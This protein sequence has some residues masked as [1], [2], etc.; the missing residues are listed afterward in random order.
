VM[1]VARRPTYITGRVAR[2]VAPSDSRAGGRN[3]A[4]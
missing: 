1:Y 3:D 2:A 4:I